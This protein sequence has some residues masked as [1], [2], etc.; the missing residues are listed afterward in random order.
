MSRLPRRD[1]IFARG[2]NKGG[3]LD[4]PEI[5]RHARKADP[6][7]NS[8]P[9]LVMHVTQ[10]EAVAVRLVSAY[11]RRQDHLTQIKA[12]EIRRL[13]VQVRLR[14]QVRKFSLW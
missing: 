12:I 2:Q 1:V 8:K 5:N 3:C 7:R 11:L 6:S 13:R 9:V 10:I 4:P 14:K